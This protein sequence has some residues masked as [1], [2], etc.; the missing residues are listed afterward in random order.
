MNVERLLER[1]FFVGI[2]TMACLMPVHNDT[3]WHLRA[4]D[5]MLATHRVMLTDVFS[6]T[7]AGQPWANYEWLSEVVFA[8]VYGA[9]GLPGLTVVCA[10]AASA[11]L[12]FVYALIPGPTVHRILLLAGVV[13]GVTLTWSVRPQVFSL[14]LLGVTLWLLQR[15]AWAPLPP[16]FLLWANLH[17]AVALGILALGGTVVAWLIARRRLPRGLVIAVLLCGAATLLTPLGLS[18]WP[19]IAASILRSKTNVIAEWRA[20]DWP[21]AHL[22]FWVGAIALPLLLATRWNRL[23]SPERWSLPLTALLMLVLGLRSMRNISPFLMAAA[24]ACGV[25]LAAREAMPHAREIVHRGRILTAIILAVAIGGAAGYVWR[26]WQNPPSRMGW[27]PV[28]PAAARAIESCRGPIYNHYKD[29]GPIIYFAPRQP[30][31]LDSRQDPYPVPLVQAEGQVEATG[32]YHRL[33][34]SL[35]VN[36]VVIPPGGRLAARLHADG[37]HERFTDPDWLV[38]ERP[39]S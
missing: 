31:M 10:A 8:I 39:G 36:C 15:R 21:P 7:V 22:A 27:Y 25:L 35:G 9:G 23:E 16:L 24:P 28:S 3:W 37:W 29:G 12:A 17:G 13:A 38:L 34:D 30:V 32:D 2:V 26:T 1:L 33:F 6:Y 11:S 20:P 19:E 4:G 5:V 14:L 18:Y